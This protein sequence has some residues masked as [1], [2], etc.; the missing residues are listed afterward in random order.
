MER[1]KIF[2][3]E[4]RCLLAAFAIGSS[5]IA[6]VAGP[7]E[8]GQALYKAGKYA[9]VDD[10]LAAIIEKRPVAM[11]ALELSFNASIKAGRPYTAERRYNAMVEKGGKIKPEILFKAAMISGTIGKPN[12]RRDRLI[13][14]LKTE[15]GWNDNVATALQV[16]CRDGGDGD[17]FVRLMTSEKPTEGHFG[18]GMGMLAQLRAAKRNGDYLKVADT[19]LAKFPD[20]SHVTIVLSEVRRMMRE[21]AAPEVFRANMLSVLVKHP[22]AKNGDFIDLARTTSEFGA[23]HVIDYSAFNK[24]LLPID[25]FSRI[26]NLKGAVADQKERETY[27]PKFKNMKALVMAAA[28]KPAAGAATVYEPD[29]LRYY[30]AA[31]LANADLFRNANAPAVFPKADLAQMFSVVATAKYNSDPAAIRTLANDC[32]LNKAWEPAHQTTII[33]TYPKLFD[34]R[35]LFYNSKLAEDARKT[36]NGAKIRELLAKMPERHDIRM[37]CLP[38]FF[39]IKDGAMLKQI[40]QEH[41]LANPLDFESDNIARYFLSSDAFGPAERSNFL[42]DIFAKTG[43]S[44]AWRRLVTFGALPQSLKDDAAFKA[45]VETVKPEAKGTDPIAGSLVAISQVKPGAGNVLPPEAFE[46]AKKAVKAYGGKIPNEAN[47]VKARPVEKIWS[48]MTG[49]C[50]TR[51]DKARLLDIFVP[52]FANRADFAS[53][54]AVAR[55]TQNQTNYLAVATAAIKAGSMRPDEFSQMV[56]PKGYP[57][58]VLAPYYK[59]MTPVSALAHVNLNCKQ[60][61][62]PVAERFKQIGLVYGAHPVAQF[63]PEQVRETFEIYERMITYTNLY[64][65]QINLEPFAVALIDNRIGTSW[66]RAYLVKLYSMLGKRDAALTRFFN[67]VAKADPYAQYADIKALCGQQYQLPYVS[68]RNWIAVINLE[69]VKDE[70]KANDFGAILRDKLL[71][72]IKA[73]P[74]RNAA[75]LPDFDNGR[76]ADL[77]GGIVARAGD[78]QAIKTVSEASYAFA[79]EYAKRACLGMRLGIERFRQYYLL[80]TAYSRFVAANEGE[81]L[82]NIASALGLSFSNGLDREGG[83]FFAVLKNGTK[84]G[85]WEPAHLAA[86]VVPHETPGVAANA[87]R[88]RS[89]C[90]T[91]MPG[92]YP[93]DESSPMYPL[94]VAADELE[95][96]NSERSWLL[97]SKNLQ[98]FEREASKLPAGFVAWGVEQLR[99]ARGK[100]DALLIRARKIASA[101]LSKEST[102]TPELAASLMLTRA[103]CYRDQRN[104][105]AAKLEYQSI[106]NGNY[107]RGTKAARKA[108]FRDVDL[109]IEMGNATQAEGIIELWMSQPDA[110]IQAQAH[111]F[112]ARISFDRKDYEDTR[113]QL[114]EV[115]NLDYTHTEARLLHGQWKLATNSEVDDTDVLVGDLADRTLIRPGQEL[116]ISVMDRNLGI[117]GGGNSIPIIV[118]TSEGK[119]SELL[120]LYPSPRNPYLFSGSISTMLGPATATNHILEVCGNDQVSYRVEEEFLKARGLETTPP[121]TLR[122][123]DDARLAIGAA[124][125][126]AEDSRAEAALEAMILMANSGGD[127]DESLAHNLKPGNPLY[128]VVRDRDRSITTSPDKISV[129]ARTSSGDR[130][131]GIVLEETEGSSG[132][133][134]GSI[135]TR[136][137]PPRAFASDTAT[138]YNPGDAINSKR[139]GIWKSSP[140]GAQGKWFEVDTMGS[141][142]V[143]NVAIMMPNS[144]DISSIRLVGSFTSASTVLGALPITDVSSRYGIKYQAAT[145]RKL[146]SAGLIRSTF[147]SSDA[148]APRRV[149]DLGF[150][151]ISKRDAAQNAMLSVPFMLTNN[152][153]TVKFELQAANPRGR[154]LA[155]LWM[156]IAVDGVVVFTGQ[157]NSLDGQQVTFDVNP[158][159]HRLE[160]FFSASYPEDALRIKVVD[161]NGNLHS[162]PNAWIDPKVSPELT[163]FVSDVATIHRVKGGFQ[164]TFSRPMR[165]RSLRWEF[166]GYSGREISVN[167]L[168]VQDN[169]GKMIIPVESDFSDALQNDTL[170]VAPG[171]QITVSYTDDRTSSGERR[172]LERPIKSS[173]HNARVNFF[174]EEIVPT[175]DGTRSMLFNAYRFIPGDMMIVSVRDPDGDITP[176]A[177]TIEVEI[178]T[179]SGKRSKMKLKEQVGRFSNLAGGGFY[180][181]HDGIR[182]IHGG[183]FVGILRTCEATATNVPAG[184]LPIAPGDVISLHY[185]DREN[186]SPGVPTIRAVSVAA[187]QPSATQVQFFDT[188]VSRVVDTSYDAK[189]RL[190]QIRRR[191][192]NERIE[193]LYKDV[194]SARMIPSERLEGTNVLNMNVAA[195]IPIMVTAPSR[196]RHEASRINVEVVAQSELD[197]AEASERDPETL[198]FPLRL[199]N[200]FG[201]IKTDA[202]V[203]RSVT[204]A[205][206]IGA[207]TGVI[208]LHLGP[209][210]PSAEIDED[211]LPP[212][213]VNGNDQ[214]RIRVLGDNGS[215]VEE[216]YIQLVSAARINL[217]DSTYSADRHM[218][219]VGERFFVI[220]EDADQ[221]DGEELNEVEITVRTTESKITRKAILKE[222]LP[223][224]GIFTGTIRPVIFAPGE[225][226]P[227]IAT[228]GVAVAEEEFLDDRI[229]VKYGDT[230]EFFYDDKVTIPS[231]Q[232]GVISVSG[233]VFKGSDGDIRVFSK[234]FRDSDMAV[235]VQFRLAECLFETAK[236]FRR[237]KQP[238]RSATTI[239]EGKRILEEALRDY[240]TTIHL[241]QGEY[242]LANLY[243][244]LAT[245]EKTAG[246]MEA[247]TPLYSEA[248]SRFSAILST[249][250]DSDFAARAQY[251]KALCLEMLGDYNSASEEYVKMTYLY[252]ES[253]LVGDASIR[254]ATFYY[255]QKQYST[256]GRIYHS[257]QRRFPTHEKADRA[258]FMAA[259]CHMKQASFLA[260]EAEAKK[261]EPPRYLMNEEYKLAVEALAL[262]TEQYRE[263]ASIQLRSQALYWAGDASLKCGDYQNA[264]L[265]LKRTVFEYPETEWARRARGLLLQEAGAFEDLE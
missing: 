27:A 197:D 164:A 185:N 189:L 155:G 24:A 222:T 201:A 104:Y 159:P 258:L 121:K 93:V 163:Q 227:S 36:K 174:F 179:R 38:V 223:H 196:A 89:D 1:T 176:N 110:E 46:L 241:V 169:A 3:M 58:S 173:F 99:Y 259:Q 230:V 94:Y 42:K 20:D 157:G 186:T 221:D 207:F 251:H 158:G 127:D 220:V 6:A 154:T 100:E 256:A 192:G 19:L 45:F 123:V 133:F 130:I 148:P 156:A 54:L 239:D 210:D 190:E 69:G 143:S 129:S 253:P 260:E 248:L 108:M 252:P 60:G 243:Q 142:V 244:E 48:I 255:R 61:N 12:I 81:Y 53:P 91:H 72:A 86:S 73:I 237:L 263:T 112:L 226:I 7:I 202:P 28:T 213:C 262:L 43:Y 52:I 47:P 35:S 79:E 151:P 11:E 182:G 229:S 168:Y 84:A 246:N 249:W 116:T 191:P 109:L 70:P 219:H 118:S 10:A 44:D 113:K 195:P 257:F 17:H 228:G 199:G 131:D 34:Y 200:H 29:Y 106:R 177:D 2:S 147:A 162:F 152:Q 14:F 13:Y 95:R 132:V 224:S 160:M 120:S 102:L 76:F 225:A 122:I 67:S 65:G 5:V 205:G 23:Q 215:I 146:N 171:D 204:A 25:L 265:Y 149:L 82:A 145:G 98:T 26:V 216:R 250:P 184:T 261:E 111:Y 187:S 238:E 33:N 40:T 254:L 105:E 30:I 214:L 4:T 124:A 97:L 83:A 59:T 136:L 114:D 125:P 51:E 188:S 87:Q 264:Y 64:N 218:A 170:E 234:R 56:Y 9:E 141:H 66:D 78:K 77:L 15:T 209:P 235:L 21:A 211:E 75:L 107:Y 138:G 166:L 71:P 37:Q 175:R 194:I 180:N 92:I 153:K 126:L 236:E 203:S 88:L 167:K 128:V 137:P 172:V 193:K 55:D 50:R 8:D 245:E 22:L 231:R 165:L 247:A 117:A 208:K 103:E 150:T 140:D 96:N 161:D 62:W 144:E 39:D 242:L 119:D 240:P 80:R 212:V 41:I 178:S 181:K 217:M 198:I 63:R 115:F 85:F 233:K 57:T 16:L 101:L 139:K 183:H 18:L 74:L 232:P 68:G 90:S 135:P 32:V 134:R 49:L 31:I 206:R